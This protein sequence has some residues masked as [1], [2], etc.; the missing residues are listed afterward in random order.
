MCESI[1]TKPLT[2]KDT[3]RI[4]NLFSVQLK[5]LV[6]P[7]QCCSDIFFCFLNSIYYEVPRYLYT[8]E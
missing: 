5:L 3:Q 4:K 7:L 2:V 1:V 8:F 6:R